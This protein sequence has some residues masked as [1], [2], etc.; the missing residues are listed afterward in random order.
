MITLTLEYQGKIDKTLSSTNKDLSKLRKTFQEIE[1]ELP[2]SE[3][4]NRKLHE[5]IGSK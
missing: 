3:N 2:L 1:S 4:I 5:Q